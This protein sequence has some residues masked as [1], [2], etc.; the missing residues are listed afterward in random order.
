MMQEH[1]FNIYPEKLTHSKYLQTGKVLIWISAILIV[2]EMILFIYSNMALNLDDGEGT[3]LFNMGITFVSFMR[4]L[5]IALVFLILSYYSL[6]FKL[7]VVRKVLIAYIFV[8]LFHRVWLWFI[9]PVITSS[10]ISMHQAG[11]TDI[12]TVGNMLSIIAYI[13]SFFFTAAFAFIY[14]VA[15][16]KFYRCKND[17][18]GGLRRLGLVFLLFAIK[19]VIAE[20]VWFLL[21]ALN[22]QNSSYKIFNIASVIL[23]I[24]ISLYLIFCIYRVFSNAQ[25]YIFE[26]N[27]DKTPD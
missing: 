13:S 7:P 1:D 26:K 8:Y 19:R 17:Y 6:N 20:F 2:T 25:Q 12:A 5:I 3:N 9:Q 4:N 21:T 22:V 27:Y 16:V 15:G 18:I 11:E 10:I 14:T 24:V 23:S